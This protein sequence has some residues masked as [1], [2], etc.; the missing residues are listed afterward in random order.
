MAKHDKHRALG[1]ETENPTQTKT[2]KKEK[3]LPAEVID[4]RDLNETLLLLT[5]RP[6][7]TFPFQPGQYVKLA[8][9]A[10]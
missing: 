7:Q 5:V 8:I 10:V 1:S 6:T 9:D 4:R 3:W 2:A